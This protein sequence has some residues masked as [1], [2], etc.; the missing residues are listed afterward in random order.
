[1]KNSMIVLAVLL[2]VTVGVTG[3]ALITP[4]ARNVEKIQTLVKYTQQG[5]FD[6][7]VTSL[8]TYLQD[9]EVATETESKAIPLSYIESFIVTY[10]FV[11]DSST[12]G[13]I[14]IDAILENP[15]SWQ[16]KITMASS[17]AEGSLSFPIDLSELLDTADAINKEIGLS[18]GFTKLI[19]RATVTNG[20]TY[21]GT[22]DDFIQDLPVELNRTMVKIG[23]GL[24]MSREN[25]TGVFGY[26]IQLSENLLYGPT[27]IT[28]PGQTNAA[29][30]TLGPKDT[31]FLKLVQ[32]ID[33]N[34]SYNITA[35]PSLQQLNSELTVEA[36]VANPK[37]WS[38]TFELIPTKTYNGDIIISF[39]IDLDRF[40]ELYDNIQK[41]TGVVA[42][43][44]QVTLVATVNT[45]GQ[46]QRGQINETF[47]QSITTNLRTGVLSWGGE[48]E[49][50]TPGTIENQQVVTEAVRLF[51]R[52]V[53]EIRIIGAILTVTLLILL[54]LFLWYGRRQQ[55]VAAYQLAKKA[56]EM[57]RKYNNLFVQVQGIPEDGSGYT[58]LPV[59]SIE[60][61]VKVGQELLKPVNHAQDNDVH[62]YWVYDDHKRYEYQLVYEKPVDIVHDKTD[63]KDSSSPPQFHNMN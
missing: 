42:S 37:V 49:K 22:T 28:P 12:I 16:K 9:E 15:N 10:N 18:A 48:L 21:S 5:N 1:M 39:P 47:T 13:N 57:E 7:Q 36:I 32:G 29:S 40:S 31:I 35:E 34:Y 43:E 59:D 60:D 6:Y 51:S 11:S 56:A 33:V 23:S 61:L 53:L 2:L 4:S 14:N 27:L 19:I 17:S 41:E 24:K 26:Q 25:A 63:V 52:P 44:Q 38:K 30:V 58:I 50:T 3:K 20:I 8:P 62:R 54:G 45:T 46:T 55:D